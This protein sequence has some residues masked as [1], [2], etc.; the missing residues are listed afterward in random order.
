M[1]RFCERRHATRELERID[2][3]APERRP[4]VRAR[5]PAQADPD[6][7]QPPESD[8][9]SSRD[10]GSPSEMFSGSGIPSSTLSL[11]ESKSQVSLQAESLPAQVSVVTAQDIERLNIRNYSDL[12]ATVPGVNA[13]TI[14]QGQATHS[15]S[16][17]GF[18]GA[19][20]ADVAIF[21]DGVPQ[22]TP[23]TYQGSTGLSEISWLAPE[24]IERMEI[25]KGPFSALY[26]DFAMAG[27]INIITKK[28]AP[29]SSVSSYGGSFG[30]FRA[31]GEVGSETLV[32][33]PYLA[34]EYYT[35]DGYRDNS[36]LNS[37]SPFNKVSM[38]LLGGI[39]SL[40]Y[41]YYH[42]DWGAPG[43]LVIDDV[44]KG[45]VN[46]K[47]A[48][49]TTDGGDQTR[50]EVVLNYAPSCGERGLYATAYVDVWDIIRY[51][52]WPPGPQTAR[53][54]TRTY[55][56]GRLYYNMVFGDT[57]TL[58]LGG[59][60]RLDTASPQDHKTNGARQF[61]GTNYNYDLKLS[62]WAWFLQ[63][64][65]KPAEKLKI[66]GG[67]RG[68]YFKMEAENLTRPQN[69]GTGFRQIIAPKIGAVL[70]P[71]TDF[72]I[73][74]NIG[75]G[76]RS[77][78]YTEVSPYSANSNKNFNLEPAK[79]DTADVGFNVALFG[80]L[81]FAAA[82][83]HTITEREIRL[84]NNVPTNIGDTLRKG[85]EVEAKFYPSRDVSVFASYDW[86]DASVI[87]PAK[88]GQVLVTRVPEHIIKGGLQ[89]RRDFGEGRRLLA[90]AYYQYT[91]GFPNYNG[92]N[93][94]P[95]FGPDYDVYSFKLS[96]MG[97]G[98]SSFVSA[99]YQPRE[100][101]APVAF[102]LNGELSY[103]PEP[104]WDFT[105]GLTYTFW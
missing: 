55:W 88:A 96:Y 54:D 92:S 16:I 2:I 62:N 44:R 26:G 77:P 86:V 1:I 99:R 79:V 37:F 11:V 71:T 46:R 73:F 43:Y 102:L 75:F 95:V 5:T 63:G 33:I 34:Y 50:Q 23:S 83:Y 105:S 22:S 28:S 30:T 3:E 39:L 52:D 56:G 47:H 35:T 10:R 68:D 8:S 53:E 60:T 4:A 15:F 98:W 40:R 85:Y 13:Y 76:F 58:T 19:G 57:A 69:S 9:R 7:D 21:I 45:L 18:A 72:N 67:V 70:T 84:V 41:N 82:Y 61:T 103:A 31:L 64:Q 32:P 24:A 78:S 94:T 89:I 42:S 36:Q 51:N 12:F 66:V 100:F 49:N 59:E 17:R 48:Y 25:I 87:N 65:I 14:G 93:P 81:Y 97:T 74:G 27:V 104:K 6:F 38:P 20:G 101:S 91:S 80:N 29:A 90:D